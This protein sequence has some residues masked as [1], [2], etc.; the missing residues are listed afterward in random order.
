MNLTWYRDLLNNPA[1][2]TKKAKTIF[3]IDQIEISDAR[4]SLINHS[5]LR[6]KTKLD[7]NN[8]NLTGINGIIEDFKIQ[9]DT[10]NTHPKKKEP[11]KSLKNPIKRGKLKAPI[12]PHVL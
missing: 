6:A 11:V 10:T 2:S 9:D 8:L 4:F 7:F 12:D 5:G 3:S 1:D